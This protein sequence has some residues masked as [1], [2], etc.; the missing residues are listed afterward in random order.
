MRGGFYSRRG[1]NWVR[2]PL[3]DL[4]D[5]PGLEAAGADLNRL[6]STGDFGSNLEEVG[7]P[8]SPRAVL[9]VGNGVAEY[10]AFAANLASS[11][12]TSS[13]IE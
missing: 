12:H 4:F 9:S 1:S 10:R 2:W 11:G 3:D 7:P 8:G 13:P 5:L 6:D